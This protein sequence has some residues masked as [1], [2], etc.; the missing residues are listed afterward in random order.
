MLPTLIHT[1]E[2]LD[3]IQTA[4]VHML[5]CDVQHALKL[6]KDHSMGRICHMVVKS[7]YTPR[8]HITTLHCELWLQ[9]CLLLGYPAKPLEPR[10]INQLPLF[11]LPRRG[12][13]TPTLPPD[14]IEARSNTR[15]RQCQAVRLVRAVKATLEQILHDRPSG[16]IRALCSAHHHLL[17]RCFGHPCG[18]RSIRQQTC[19][20]LWYFKASQNIL[21]LSCGCN[22]R[23]PLPQRQGGFHHERLE[24]PHVRQHRYREHQCWT[25]L[26]PYLQAPRVCTAHATQECLKSCAGA[27]PWQHG[28]DLQIGAL[29]CTRWR[30]PPSQ[31]AEERD[32]VQHG[33]RDPKFVHRLSVLHLHQHRRFATE[34]V[35]AE[36]VACGLCIRG[37]CRLRSSGVNAGRSRD[38]RVHGGVGRTERV[39]LNGNTHWIGVG[40]VCCGSILPCH[41]RVGRCWWRGRRTL[42][43]EFRTPGR[44]H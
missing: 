44:A 33:S 1:N 12:W 41:G 15:E 2:E 43:H 40:G 28:C 14:V 30:R 32:A 16:R 38:T 29:R 4:R 42:R 3:D 21:H 6:L 36:Q 35:S 23:H 9:S 7:Q 34:D 10:D 19:K 18:F 11:P 20:R 5:R 25:K 22:V 26:A 39:D 17:K 13:A 8:E 24:A 31:R 27:K 37:G